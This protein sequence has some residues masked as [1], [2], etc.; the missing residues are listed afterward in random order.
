MQELYTDMHTKH[1]HGHTY[2]LGN[3]YTLSLRSPGAM[4]YEEGTH[5]SIGSA[6]SSTHTCVFIDCSLCQLTKEEK[7][8]PVFW[9]ALCDILAIAKI[10]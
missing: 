2:Q 6:F 5:I 8:K 7:I 9:M 10:N 4:S 3:I 1:A